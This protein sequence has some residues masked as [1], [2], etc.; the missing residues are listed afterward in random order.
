M[1]KRNLI[2]I[3]FGILYTFIGLII[4]LSSATIGFMPMGF[5]MGRAISLKSNTLL[6]VMGF[7][8]GAVVV[9][10]EP[11][12]HVLTKQVEDITTG[13]VKKMSMLIALSIGVGL[14]L[15]MSMIRIIFNF[16]ILYYIVPGY[17]ISLSLA[18]FVPKMYTAIAFDS[19]GVASGPLTSSFILPFAIG[20]CVSISGVDNVL[21]NGFGIVSMVALTPLITIQLLGFKDIILKLI[22]KRNRLKKIEVSRDEVIIRF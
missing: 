8:F 4:F 9:L 20:A 14:S 21:T 1:S 15:M 19:G 3:G 10:A 11:A 5:H 16:S 2:K 7:I 22:K 17:I 18:F 13:G 6:C 12:V